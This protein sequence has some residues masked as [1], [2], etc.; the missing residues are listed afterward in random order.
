MKRLSSLMTL[1]ILAISVMAQPSVSPKDD[2]VERTTLA[3]ER[4]L[5]DPPL[6]EADILWEKRIWRVIDTREKMNLPFRYP[7][8]PLF[9]ILTSAIEAREL[10]AY[11]TED[12]KFSTPLSIEEISAKLSSIDTVAIYNPDGGSEEYTIVENE[13]DPRDVKRYRLKEVWYFDSRRGKLEVRILGIAPMKEEYDDNGNFKYE[14][15]LFWI[16][17]PEARYVLSDYKV[18]NPWNDRGQMSWTD[19]FDMRQFSSYVIKGSNI[20]DRRLQDY[21]AGRDLLLQSERI[22]GGIFNHESQ[23]WQD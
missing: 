4:F 9:S 8:Q 18:Y 7:D 13:I 17:F 11:S 6:R 22:E 3:N 16:Y 14:H 23:M 21:L 20:H 1:V 15:P 5:P 19:L 10:Q 2:I 12:D